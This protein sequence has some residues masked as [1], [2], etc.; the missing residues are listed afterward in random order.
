MKNMRWILIILALLFG[1]TLIVI[2]LFA[3][4]E[5]LPT[6]LMKLKEQYENRKFDLGTKR[7]DHSKFAV[8]QQKFETPQEVTKACIS[9]HN[10]TAKDIMNGNHWNWERVE[11]IKNRGIVYLGKRNAINNFC[12]SIVNSEKVCAKCHIG[13]GISSS[14]LGYTD[15]TNIDC[16]ICHDN[17]GTY[18]KASN[19]AGAP[20]KNVNF[21][22]VAQNVGK[23][24][25]VNCGA[26]H[27]FGGGGNNVKHGDLEVSLLE[28]TTSVDVHMGI[29]GLNL[30]CIDCHTTK[31]HNIAGKLYSLSSMNIHRV[32]CEQ[33]HTSTPH[34]KEI[35]N[36]HTLKVACQTCHIPRYATMKPTKVEWDWSVAGKLVDGKPISLTDSLGNVVYT[37]QKGQFVWGRNLKPDYI[38]FNG[39][40]SHYLA[41]DRVEDTTKPLVLNQLHGSYDDPDSKIYPVKIHYGRQPFDPVNKILI[42][43]KLFGEKPGEGGFWVDF[44]WQTASRIGMQTLGL[45]FSG[46]VTFIRTIMYWPV[47]HM[48]AKKENSV[49]CIECHTRKDSRLAN[50]TGF[51]LP[52]R[53]KSEFVDTGGLILILVV[54]LLVVI[55]S[56]LRVYFYV[57]TKKGV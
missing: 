30:Q 43:P 8:L 46:S 10:Q 52:G 49:Q 19:A 31:R 51:Y 38:W 39:T 18:A 53:D 29:D 23:P 35:L 15:S 17:S 9:C 45:P 4:K 37:S 47:N 34:T 3:P 33:C 32:E 25:N 2:N 40:S 21:N 11:Y 48:V 20:D 24:Q 13:Y 16:L 1:V 6:K 41:G 50:L 54:F 12:L 22:L 5:L 55:H 7:T 26:C 42:Q 57:K 28:A 36:E 27:F 14:G 56:S 44:D